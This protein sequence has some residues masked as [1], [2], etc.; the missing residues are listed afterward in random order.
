MKKS[1]M[2]EMKLR[3]YLKEEGIKQEPFAR[4]VGVSPY[5]LRCAMNG[6]R[7]MPLSLACRIEDVTRGFDGKPQVTCRDLVNPLYIKKLENRSKEL[8]EREGK[9]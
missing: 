6:T 7:E 1:E 3:Q 9:K 2:H 5:T 4:K 8:K